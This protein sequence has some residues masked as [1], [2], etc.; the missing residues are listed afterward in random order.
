MPFTGC[1]TNVLTNGPI[2]Y[3]PNCCKKRSFLNH[4]LRPQIFSIRLFFMG[5]T[6][7][8]DDVRFTYITTEPV[9][10]LSRVMANNADNALDEM[11]QKHSEARTLCLL[12]KPTCPAVKGCP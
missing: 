4:L 6:T 11:A 5:L 12:C 1:T 10:T 2:T 3:E 9:H 7:Y 8:A